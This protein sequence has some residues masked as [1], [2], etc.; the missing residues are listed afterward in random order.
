MS[1]DWPTIKKPAK[2]ATKTDVKWD[3]H[4]QQWVPTLPKVKK[5]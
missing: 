4:M 3:Y 2:P 5:A 1:K